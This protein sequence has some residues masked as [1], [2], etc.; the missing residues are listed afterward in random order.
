M[1]LE[2]RLGFNPRGLLATAR[3][4]GWVSGPPISSRYSGYKV[5]PSNFRAPNH[6]GNRQSNP[7]HATRDTLPPF[8]ATRPDG[9]RHLYGTKK[10]RRDGTSVYSETWIHPDKFEAEYAQRLK[11]GFTVIELLTV[12]ALMAILACIALPAVARAIDH[13]RQRV[14]EISEYKNESLQSALADNFTNRTT[15]LSVRELSKLNQS[16]VPN[17]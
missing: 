1:T 14:E 3:Q 12:I 9:Y 16:E 2:Q 7:L 4:K 5:R 11:T 8:G 17:P 13:A 6:H 10:T 15:V